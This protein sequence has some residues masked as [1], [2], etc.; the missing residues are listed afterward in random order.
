[1]VARAPIARTGAM[2]R[3][4]SC[5]AVRSDASATRGTNSGSCDDGAGL[6]MGRYLPSFVCDNITRPSCAISIDS[7]EISFFEA[8][9]S[10]SSQLQTQPREKRPLA[11][12]PT[13]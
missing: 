13:G 12:L 7:I 10:D 3:R 9:K 4:A 5:V 6:L 11:Q 1:R 8:S 2:M